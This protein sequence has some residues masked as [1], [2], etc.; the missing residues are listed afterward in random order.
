M[1]PPAKS[2]GAPDLW[3][4]SGLGLEFVGIVAGFIFLGWLL[5]RWLGTLPWITLVSA[6]FGLVGGSY[7]FAREAMQASRRANEAYRREHGGH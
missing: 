5:D 1:A 6:V 3:R 4:I 2:S 7:K